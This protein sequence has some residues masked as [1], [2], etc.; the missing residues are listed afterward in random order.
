MNIRKLRADWLWQLALLTK[1]VKGP[2]QAG[3]DAYLNQVRIERD[4]KHPVLIAMDGAC[5]SVIR[6]TESEDTR[7]HKP[8][9]LMIAG[10]LRSALSKAGPQ[11]RERRTVDLDLDGEK[12]PRISIRKDDA[13]VQIIDGEA[14]DPLVKRDHKYPAWTRIL[15]KEYRMKGAWKAAVEGEM[16][17]NA[18]NIHL[19]A[20]LPR[21]GAVGGISIQPVLIRSDLNYGTDQTTACFIVREPGFEHRAFSMLAP[22]KGMLPFEMPLPEFVKRVLE[23]NESRRTLRSERHRAGD[24]AFSVSRPTNSNESEGRPSWRPWTSSTASSLP[25]GT[26]SAGYFWPPSSLSF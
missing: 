8:I 12:Q 15:P 14:A 19:L 18:I 7:A 9:T 2:N 21:F 6:C 10:D 1:A 5:M 4:G 13:I 24:H 16:K 3:S 26:T 20:K 22:T 23:A 17:M 25:S 11:G